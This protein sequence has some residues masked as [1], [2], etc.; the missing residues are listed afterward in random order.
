MT[1]AGTHEWTSWSWWSKAGHTENRR[2]QGD[3]V[4]S[5]VLGRPGPGGD[6]L[7]TCSAVGGRPPIW[8]SLRWVGQGRWR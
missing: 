2:E 1:G 6:G 8:S 5:L 4:V 7:S 3:H